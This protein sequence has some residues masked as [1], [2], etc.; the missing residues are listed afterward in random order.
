MHPYQM[1]Q[2]ASQRAAELRAQKAHLARRHVQHPGPRNSVRH[3]A[4]WTLVE[5]GLR[6]AGGSDDA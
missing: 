5:I 3:R 6:L 1:E 2:I 4:G